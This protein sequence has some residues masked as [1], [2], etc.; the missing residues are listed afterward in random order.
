CAG[1][2]FGAFHTPVVRAGEQ[3]GQ[4]RGE[5]AAGVGGPHRIVSVIA[6][7]REAQGQRDGLL[8]LRVRLGRARLPYDVPRQHRIG[9]GRPAW[10]LGER[11][12][13]PRIETGVVASVLRKIRA[14]AVAL[15]HPYL[16]VRSAPA[17]LPI[18]DGELVLAFVEAH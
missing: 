16:G 6:P 9:R 14:V 7:T 3:T 2:V 17:Y 13:Q 12:H 4:G 8:L 5:V 15:L 1:E 10:S 11:E 18:D